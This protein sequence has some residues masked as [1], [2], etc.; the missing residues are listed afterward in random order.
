MCE[1][2]ILCCRMYVFSSHQGHALHVPPL[3]T[4]AHDMIMLGKGIAP[5]QRTDPHLEV[6]RSP[7]GATDEAQ[8]SGGAPLVVKA[9]PAPAK[10]TA[11]A[12]LIGAAERAAAAEPEAL[13]P[14]AGGE[15]GRGLETALQDNTPVGNRVLKAPLPHRDMVERAHG[16]DMVSGDGPTD[17]SRMPSQCHH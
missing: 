12:E 8:E 4:L 16:R 9:V 5:V 15:S 13:E 1:E 11:S 6:L 2:G 14:W 17:G 7:D 3:D 10:G